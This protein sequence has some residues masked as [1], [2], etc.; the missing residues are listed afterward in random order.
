[1]QIRMFLDR[2]RTARLVG[3]L[4]GGFAV[5]DPD[6]RGA[7][8]D[9]EPPGEQDHALLRQIAS[10]N[11]EGNLRRISWLSQKAGIPLL[12]V[13]QAQ[14]EDICGPGSASGTEGAEEPDCFP[15]QAHKA[16]LM[17]ASA[18]GGVP[19][20]DASSALRDRSMQPLIGERWF[21]DVI[22]LTREGNATLGEAVAPE[23]LRL[24]G[25]GRPPSP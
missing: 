6:P 21:Q 2:F 11:L 17:A 24:L 13:A 3:S 1:M 25:G 4:A 7:W 14:N 22:H 5:L 23:A 12:F 10:S 9:P 15:P 19:V 20:V 8:L 16:L 18:M